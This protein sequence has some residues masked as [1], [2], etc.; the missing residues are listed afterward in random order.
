VRSIKGFIPQ[1]TKEVNN[2]HKG[3]KLTAE[4]KQELISIRASE[5]A[6]EQVGNIETEGLRYTKSL[7]DIFLCGW[8]GKNFPPFPKEGKPSDYLML[9]V[10]NKLARAINDISGELCGLT[11]SDSKN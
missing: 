10:L 1:A 5:L 2:A 3:L 8:E 9:P 4:K 11:V 7:V 6:A